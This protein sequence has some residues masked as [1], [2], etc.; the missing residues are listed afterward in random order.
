MPYPLSVRSTPLKPWEATSQM[1]LLATRTL[2][3]VLVAPRR[4]PLLPQPVVLLCLTSLI[5]LRAM[6]PP[7]IVPK[8]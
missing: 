8:I 4:I 3:A 6:V 2:E 7:L 1:K 5:L